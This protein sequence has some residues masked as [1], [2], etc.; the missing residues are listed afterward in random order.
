M[1]EHG[2]KANKKRESG[3]ANA[4]EN[5]RQRY[6]QNPALEFPAKLPLFLLRL[7]DFG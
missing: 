4:S 6:P 3:D 2:Q 5:K 7:L 1:H